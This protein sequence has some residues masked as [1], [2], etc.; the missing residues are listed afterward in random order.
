MMPDYAKSSKMMKN[1]EIMPSGTPEIG[2]KQEKINNARVHVHTKEEK[3]REI[4]KANIMG[5]LSKLKG[6]IIHNPF[7]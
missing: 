1:D 3:K 5:G 4:G 2:K 7:A 6:T